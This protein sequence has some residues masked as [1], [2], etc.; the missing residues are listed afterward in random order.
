MLK[1]IGLMLAAAIILLLAYA[2]TRPD[3]FSVQRSVTINAAPDKLLPLLTD[4]HRWPEWSPWEKLDP[5]MKRTHSGAANG[6]G[7]IYEWDGNDKVGAGRMEVTGIQ[8]P[9]KVSIKLDFMRPFK[10]QNTTEY[11]L[12]SKGSATEVTWTMFGPSPFISK[13]MGVFVSMDKMIGKDFEAGLANM[14]A[15]AEKP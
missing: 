12:V 11:A 14:K 8:A 15:V 3:S 9:S 1:T 4:F 10:S 5:T 7:A 2:A 13:L 6:V